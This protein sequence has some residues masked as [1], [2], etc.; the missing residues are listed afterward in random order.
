MSGQTR[1][2]DIAKVPCLSGKIELAI[3]QDHP[4]G[5]GAFDV[6][7]QFAVPI[8]PAQV[9][10]PCPGAGHARLRRH[11]GLR[12]CLPKLTSEPPVVTNAGPI[13]FSLKTN[14]ECKV[15]HTWWG[16][17]ASH[18]GLPRFPGSV[19]K[20]RGREVIRSQE[21]RIMIVALTH[22]PGCNGVTA[23]DVPTGGLS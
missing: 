14:A 6:Q 8:R 3:V 18:A 19:R 17:G 1:L 7:Q 10:A 23:R 16:R 20:P 2:G 5:G 15:D 21:G 12:Q 22:W 11:R 9:L 4:D 13:R